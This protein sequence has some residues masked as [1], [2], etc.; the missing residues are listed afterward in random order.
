MR[1]NSRYGFIFLLFFVFSLAACGQE[2]IGGWEGGPANG[3]SF[4]SSV[5]SFPASGSGSFVVR[6]TASFLYYNYRDS[7]GFTD[8]TSPG[9]GITMG[10][11]LRA[12]RLT[13]TAGPGV[14]TRW[15][16]RRYAGGGKLD[17][18][19]LGATALGEAFFQANRLTNLNV[20]SNYTQNDRYTW[21][22]G[23]LK[24]QV[25][26]RDFERATALLVGPEITGQGNRDV[27][28]Y[29][30]GGVLEWALLA[31]HV[32]IQFRSGYSRLQFRDGTLTTRPYIGVG[33]YSSF[34]ATRQ[35]P[36]PAGHSWSAK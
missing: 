24:R 4:G 30:T 20:I 23:G 21:I 33:F 25:T 15:E 36:P 34:L 27:R 3:Y 9:I 1:L 19:Q 29:Q 14:E 26:N 2:L 6:P 5:F 11:R 32:S 8:V 16:H 12:G 17:K 10:Y 13:L 7:E 18:T 28:E 35:A 31:S 22:R